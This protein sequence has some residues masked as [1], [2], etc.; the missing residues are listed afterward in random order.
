VRQPLIGITVG[1]SRGRDGF[2]YARLR[3][4]YIRAVE[5]AGGL[6]V[7]IAPVGNPKPL[8]ERLDGLLLPGGGDIDPAHYGEPMNGSQPP[9][10][11]LDELEL[12]AARHALDRD[13]PTF[14]ICRGQQ[15][16]NVALG[17]SLI[18]HM[19]GHAPEGPRDELH[20]NFRVAPESK[21]ASVLGATE[22]R[23]NS[24]HHQAI[25]R[26]ADGLEAVAWA[27]DGTIEGIEAPARTLFLAVQFHPEDLVDTHPASQRLFEQF[28]SA[29]RNPA[30]VTA[31]LAG[32]IKP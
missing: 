11:E 20:H 29:C 4:T 5:L 19:D 27:E 3:M 14:G 25:N 16:I 15:V 12:S 10:A 32:T 26:L 21:L 6:P 28:V 30:T 18:Q 24:H 31:E 9:N 17:G 22:L 8:F 2:E 7:L 13:L 23:V 1:A